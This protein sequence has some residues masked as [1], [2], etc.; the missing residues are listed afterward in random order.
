MD[1]LPIPHDDQFLN[2][3][4]KEWKLRGKFDFND[5][6]TKLALGYGAQVNKEIHDLISS[7]V[8]SYI[9]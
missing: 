8:T 7:R 1:R 4:H 3:L 6:V 5:D 9:F 2:D